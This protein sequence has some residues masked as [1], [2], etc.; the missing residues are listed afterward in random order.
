MR[1]VKLTKLQLA[2][3]IFTVRGEKK[4]YGFELELFL[5]FYSSEILTEF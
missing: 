3:E 4:S 2:L 1:R 5:E